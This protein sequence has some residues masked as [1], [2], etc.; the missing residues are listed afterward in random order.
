MYLQKFDQ[1][2]SRHRILW[3]KINQ[4]KN[5]KVKQVLLKMYESDDNGH[6]SIQA[7]YNRLT[8]QKYDES[9]VSS[10]DKSSDKILS[11]IT[12][13]TAR[14]AIIRADEELDTEQKNT[15]TERITHFFHVKRSEA[16]DAATYQKNIRAARKQQISSQEDTEAPAVE[17]QNLK[18]GVADRS[19]SQY[20]LKSEERSQI[21]Q[22]AS[23]LTPK[24]K[25]PNIKVK[26]SAENKFQQSTFLDKKENKRVVRV[27]I[28]TKEAVGAFNSQTLLDRD[29]DDLSLIAKDGDRN[30]ELKLHEIHAMEKYLKE[31]LNQ[32]HEDLDLEKKAA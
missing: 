23:P 20:V 22:E 19:S 16:Q 10:G 5:K 28:N 25:L 18:E 4:L 13:I 32:S 6:S 17:E 7:K 8:G 14:K 29:R 15:F 2:M 26:T 9:T 21:N 11:N 24:T 31:S 1:E 12:N 27:D 3:A 30:V